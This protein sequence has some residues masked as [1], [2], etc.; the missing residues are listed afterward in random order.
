M[1][2]TRSSASA[3]SVDKTPSS[4]SSDGV[5]LA[6][7]KVSSDPN[8]DGATVDVVTSQTQSIFV[9]TRTDSGKP[10]SDMEILEQVTVLNLDTGEQIPLS[11]AEDKLP[12]CLNPLSLHI[13]RLTS[14]YIR[15][16]AEYSRYYP[17][18]LCL[19]FINLNCSNSSLEKDKESDN[20]SIDSKKTYGTQL[21][22]MSVDGD[23]ISL[24]K[25]T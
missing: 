20:E 9:R 10:L 17:N 23:S 15:Y 25:K 6:P 16:C 11:I 12:Q 13:M 2:D 18:Y 4:S 8:C 19:H 21:D 1:G 22:A 14:E 3:A 5:T 24:R 7:E